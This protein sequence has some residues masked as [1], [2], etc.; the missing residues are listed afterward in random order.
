MNHRTA[1]KT[2]LNA[3]NIG[4]VPLE[5]LTNILLYHVAKGR[6]MAA[7]VIGSDQIRML[8]GE[9]TMISLNEGMAYIDDSQIIATD[10]PADN[11]VIH[12]IDTVLQPYRSN[13]WNQGR[14]GRGKPRMLGRRSIIAGRYL[15]VAGIVLDILLVL[16]VLSGCH[17]GSGP[18]V[19]EQ[20]G[21]PEAQ[22]TLLALGDSYTAGNSL[23]LQ[24]S[25]PW[26]LADSLAAD[27]D[28]LATLD[29][30]AQTGW[31]TRDLLNAVRD[32]LASGDFPPGDYGLVTLMIGV[33]NQ[34]QGMDQGVFAAEI[35]TLLELAISLAGNDPAR[36]LG[37]SIPDY[38]VTPVGELFGSARIAAEIADYNEL[39]D[40]I[41]TA[42]SVVM[43]DITPLSMLAGVEPGLVSRDGL[44][45]S[46]EMYR[47]W[48]ALM[49]PAVKRAFNMD[50]QEEY[51]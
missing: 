10:V 46:R 16:F 40:S 3:D 5:A 17:E 47:R 24:W 42:K 23:P 32:S 9:F 27:G 43:L 6:R 11:G 25:W 1:R 37:F 33:N 12:V 21:Q 20:R 26:Q 31:R 34:F 36:V 39:L 22:L 50:D 2:G 19:P 51:P 41:L 44:H 28:T 35:D 48:V 15:V 7:D 14:E 13:N 30:I 4:D 29:V 8:N 38:G 49:L 45:Y 18:T